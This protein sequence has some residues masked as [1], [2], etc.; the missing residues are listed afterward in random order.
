MLTCEG[1]G[2]YDDVMVALEETSKAR[3]AM[4]ECSPPDCLYPTLFFN[5]R[6]RN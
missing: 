5:I 2:N 6:Q 3:I 1:S 4:A